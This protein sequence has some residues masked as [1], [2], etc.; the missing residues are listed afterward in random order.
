[1]RIF[2][3][4]NLS[5]SQKNVHLVKHFLVSFMDSVEASHTVKP[6]TEQK[7]TTMSL[8][9]STFPYQEREPTPWLSTATPPRNP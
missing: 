5:V 1:M 3:C 9:P 6:V 4:D 7:E 8:G 2:W